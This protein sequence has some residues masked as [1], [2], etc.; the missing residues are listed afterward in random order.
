MSY[1]NTPV[2]PDIVSGIP[3][4]IP[5]DYISNQMLLKT[6]FA[7]GREARRLLWTSPRRDV[8]IYY[9][10]MSYSNA[11][12]FWEFYRSMNGPFSAFSFFFPRIRT[13]WEEAFGIS[14][15]TEAVI[16]LPCKELQTG[17]TFVL[18]RGNVTLSYPSDYALRIGEGPHGEDQAALG[19]SG[20][21]G[22]TY[23][24]SFTGRLKI[25]ARFDDRG[26]GFSEVKDLLSQVTV[27][28]TGLQSE[29]T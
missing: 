21:P 7:T 15:G 9:N 18:K 19:T 17:E 8:S 10:G 1:P 20:I 2:Y 5:F 6:N 11:N 23:F 22:Q 13:Y 12:L 25:K 27:R 14:D 29:L 28:L 3:G 4:T 26:L 24:F 16:N